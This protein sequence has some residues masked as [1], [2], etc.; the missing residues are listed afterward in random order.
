MALNLLKQQN[1]E[2][3]KLV[4]WD[5]I[6]NE[7]SSH[8]YFEENKL[9]VAINPQKSEYSSLEIQFERNERFFSFLEQND[10]KSFYDSI[11]NLSSKID[12]NSLLKRIS[13]EGILEI[14]TINQIVLS[15]EAFN[16]QKKIIEAIIEDQE[17]VS[18][19]KI[20]Q[21]I[22]RP[23]RSFVEKNGSLQE[24]S[25]P[26][27]KKIY[28][29]RIR[30]DQKAKSLLKTVVKAWDAQGILRF[31]VYDVISDCYVLPVRSD[32]FQGDLGPI[33]DRSESGNTLYIQPLE[34]E[35]VSQNRRKNSLEYEKAI[36]QICK[37]YTLKLLNFQEDLKVITQ[38]IF[39]ID[40][41]FSLA[42]FC[43]DKKLIRP[44]FSDKNEIILK[45][46]FH[47]LIENPV[48]NDFFFSEQKKGLVISGPNTGGKTVTLKAICT[49]LLLVNKGLFIPAESSI[50][51]K[52]SEIYFFSHD[53]QNILEGLSS[54]SSE[55]K[56]YL[57]L[58]DEVSPNA[59]VF[60][61]E[62]FNS[63]SSE[64][65]SALA[66]GVLEKLHEKAMPKVILSTHHQVLK[67]KTHEDQSY[68]SAH[69]GFDEG[70]PTYQFFQGTPGSSLA[71]ETFKRLAE[72]SFAKEDILF[73]AK[74]ILGNQYKEYE[75]LLMTLSYKKTQLQK[76]IDSYQNL[77]K[78]LS[79]QKAANA[80][81]LKLE[82]E[83]E[84]ENFQ[85]ELKK[86]KKKAYQALDQVKKGEIAAPKNLEK[87]FPNV[88]VNKNDKKINIE[89]EPLLEIPRV[90]DLVQHRPTGQKAI[91]QSLKGMD[92]FLL[93]N[94]KIK[95]KSKFIDLGKASEQK[96]QKQSNFKFHVEKS[97]E[98]SPIF[99]A[100]GM[101]LHEFTS[102]IEGYLSDLALN[103]IPYLEVIHGHGDGVLK[104]ELKSILKHDTRFDVNENKQTGGGS[105]IIKNC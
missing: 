28:E 21:T 67:V 37:E 43:I 103:E 12:F 20:V 36:F 54:F 8:C 46:F 64:E 26:I 51:G 11:H 25:H 47:L 1:S 22:V 97:S 29:Q 71:L 60:I 39:E 48:K 80:G 3:L 62:I 55:T 75:D 84:L 41:C 72:K 68:L 44:T 79:N 95:V 87:K 9:K 104:K 91:V 18:L 7:I 59:I 38:T 76:E 105:T 78:E 45:G 66:L 33:I 14:E 90:G 94:G 10:D 17:K 31:D 13:V 15:I 49:T 50:I 34:L 42:K 89:F 100:R 73:T 24:H 101:R 85:L 30:I 4:D 63:T 70:K 82:R 6:V 53:H 88:A 35:L 58:L 16:T 77:Q 57:E 23:F 83:K 32:R 69:M 40:Y 99:D 98:R 5:I 61:D 96:N 65:A 102:T 27:L 56:K 93:I 86:I 19:A 92:I 52:F 74:K 2:L 81:L